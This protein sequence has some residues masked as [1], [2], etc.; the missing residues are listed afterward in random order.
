MYEASYRV[1]VRSPIIHT[2]Y[3]ALRLIP[4]ETELLVASAAM[5]IAIDLAENYR[6]P[7]T[8]VFIKV[9]KKKSAEILREVSDE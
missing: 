5:Q 6:L 3:R 1:S 2:K 8:A 9:G 7:P 4:E